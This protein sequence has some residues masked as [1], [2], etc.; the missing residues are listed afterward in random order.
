MQ[1]L[2]HFLPSSLHNY[3]NQL[4]CPSIITNLPKDI[5]TIFD[6][7]MQ[8]NGTW[9]DVENLENDEFDYSQQV[10]TRQQPQHY[11][12]FSTIVA[13]AHKKFKSFFIKINWTSLK[14]AEWLMGNQLEMCNVD[15]I[16][17]HL[18]ASGAASQSVELANKLNIQNE[19]EI[20]KWC[21]IKK[22]DEFRCI[23]K[24]NKLVVICQRYLDMYFSSIEKRKNEIVT[25]IC[26]FFKESIQPCKFP[27]PDYIMDI[28][29]K[30]KVELID[31]NPLSNEYLSTTLCDADELQK[32]LEKNELTPTF[33][34]LENDKILP[35]IETAYGM[36][37]E[38]FDDDIVRTLQENPESLL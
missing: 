20:R 30:D 13:E 3:F 25:A 7:E 1:E 22:A 38:F 28:H 35:N 34:F 4:L 5:S 26:N 37:E 6:D 14:D 11:N 32:I 12:F 24:N 23:I 36:P 10:V 29:I 31:I 16:I 27:I 21:V 18:Q 8:W 2:H 9:D 15:D 19:I 17:L 33:L